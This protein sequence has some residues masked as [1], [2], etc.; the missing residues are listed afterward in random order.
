MTV[1]GTK[2]KHSNKRDFTMRRASELIPHGLFE[3]AKNCATTQ[4]IIRII[5]STTYPTEYF[6]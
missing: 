6:L 4:P 3:I 5:S 1:T 2:T